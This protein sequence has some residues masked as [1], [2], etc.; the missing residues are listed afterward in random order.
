MH[1]H[2]RG[3][4]VLTLRGSVTC[5][6]KNGLWLVPPDSALWIPG[7]TLHRSI[8]SADGAIRFLYMKPDVARL[9]SFACSLFMTPLARELIVHMT[10]V[11]SDYRSDSA[12]GHIAAVLIEQLESMPAGSG[13]CIF[14]YR[15]IIGCG[16]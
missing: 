5:E 7:G 13:G 9:P 12:D 16:P 4:L 11:A 8:V 14:R 15:I 10:R 6:L 3:Q 1:S 2:S